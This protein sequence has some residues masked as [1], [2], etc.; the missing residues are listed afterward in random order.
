[1]KSKSRIQFVTTVSVIGIII[2]TSIFVISTPGAQAA[3]P[4]VT[5]KY[6]GFQPPTMQSEKIPRWWASEVDKRTNGKLK[7]ELFHGETLGKI[8][9]FPQMLLSGV[10]DVS[11]LAAP[12]QQ[13]PVYELFA[14]PFVGHE[15]MTVSQQAFYLALHNGLFKDLSPYK[16]LW[17]QPIAP[18]YLFL[19]NKKVNSLAD[20]K[21]LKLRALGGLLTG[22]V[23][24]MGATGVTIGA[25]D[26][27]TA[28]ERGTVDGMIGWPDMVT[29]AKQ[30]EILKYCAWE[31]ILGSAGFVV[32]MSQ[33][34]FDSLPVDIQLAIEQ[35][36]RAASLEYLNQEYVTAGE[37]RA[38]LEKAGMQYYDL[39][40][41]ERARWYE[42]GK[43]FN[44]QIIAKKEAQGIPARKIADLFSR[45]RRIGKE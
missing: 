11:L 19:R 1:M 36:S 18:T 41:Q 35:A 12:P 5:L 8:G 10:C 31:P 7:V 33:A 21:G 29:F 3:A 43:K 28:L 14:L 26:L 32:A 6:A 34:K 20:F 17:R 9:D 45:M 25:A 24:A 27:Y 4:T 15:D 38:T 16:I 37:F 2:I 39:S 44:D 13:F 30:Y 40:S 23:D 22:L 42:V